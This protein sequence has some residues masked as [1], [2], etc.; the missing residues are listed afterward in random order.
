MKEAAVLLLGLFLGGC[1]Y[2][3]TNFWFLALLRGDVDSE[4]NLT[5]STG[6]TKAKHSKT[7]KAAVYCSA[8][9]EELPEGKNYL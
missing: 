1:G 6:N 4:N 8:N 9:S 5:K 3:A 2:L 7:T